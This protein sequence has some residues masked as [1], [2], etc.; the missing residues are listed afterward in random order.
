M[1]FGR[2][3]P[4]P[5]VNDGSVVFFTKDGQQT[6]PPPP[7]PGQY[8]QTYQSLHDIAVQQRDQ[9]VDGALEPLYAFW[10]N[11][12]V[13]KFNVG[14]YEEFKSMALGELG[15]GNDS[16]SKHLS[17]YYSQLLNNSLPMT[18]RIATDLVTLARQEKDS[19]RPVFHM[20]RLAWRN[21]A[22]NL[23]TRKRLGDLL[24]IEEKT[25][26]DL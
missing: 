2:A 22:T 23:K 20:I 18:D 16:G 8:Y 19:S 17:R 7:Q 9:G 12:L 21:G 6:Q 14:M 15:E 26:F 1:T 11:F 13:D 4:Q 3:S 10:S 24:T 5:F 25:E